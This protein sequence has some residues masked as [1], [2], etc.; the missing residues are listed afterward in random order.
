M[1]LNYNYSLKCAIVLYCV[2]TSA[3]AK[4]QIVPDTTLRVNSAI[5]KSGS[6]FVI[7]GGTQAGS[8]LFHSFGQF[9]VPKDTAALFNNASTIENI[10][11]RVT[12]GA[13]SNIDGVLRA[14]GTAN[15]FLIN[16]NGII[17]GPNASLNIGGSFIG[18][19]ASSINFADGTQFSVTSPQ[20][21][22]LLTVSIPVGLGFGSNPGAI[23][24]QGTGHSLM[25]KDPSF[26]PY[27]LSG[28][29]GLQV[30][31]SKTL[32]LV[33]GEIALS[34]GVLTA[35][36]GQVELGSVG[37]SDV[38][39]QVSIIPIA[40]G[41]TLDYAKVSSFGNIQ[42]GQQALVDVGGVSAG[43]IQAQGRQVSL[44]D[45]SVLW[46]QNRGL[47]P[48]GNISVNATESL[49][50]NGAAANPNIRSSLMT[51]ALKPGSSGNITVSTPRLIVQNGAAIASR[52]FGQ[53][54]GGNIQINAA[55]LIQASGYAANH[56]EAYSTIGSL[57]FSTGNAGNVAMSTR[58]VSILDGAVLA[59][60]T[61]GKG[62]S[63]NLT[64]NAETVEVN[65]VIPNSS[66]SAIATSSNGFGN[67][68][69][70]TLNT[71]TLTVKDG[72]GVSAASFGT[73]FSGSITV[74]AS[75]LVEMNGGKLELPLSTRITSSVLIQTSTFIRQLFGLPAIPNANAGSV[76][77]NT[78]VFRMTNGAVVSVKNEGSGN[79]GV[80]RINAGSLL[81][82]HQSSLGGTTKSGEGGN[83]FLQAND[84]QLRHNS[85]ITATAGGTGNGGN[86]TINSGAI[87]QLESSNITANAVKGRGGNIQIATSG[88]FPSAD[89]NI[90][91]SSQIGISGQVQIST[92]EINQ[93]NN[94][95]QQPSNFVST[96][97]VVATSC[98]AERNIAQ[99]RFVVTGNG[100]LPET[101]DADLELPYSVVQVRSSTAARNTQQSKTPAA[102][103]VPW[104]V[105]DQVLEATQLV[106]TADGR[107]LLLAN[108]T[109]A[110]ANS[111]ALTCS[112]N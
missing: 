83:I 36:G 32:A 64:I 35:P 2:L 23:A 10:F 56:P 103:S 69:N 107:L 108:P 102:S 11:A 99:G 38:P 25:A 20:T 47:Q 61:F 18:S 49:E 57:T 63:G 101:P 21:S 97:K 74:N 96:E 37:K 79:G 8:N 13:I 82:D 39:A 31:P 110:I 40:Q 48:A 12:G 54:T 78:D 90:T 41:F 16:P 104:K 9:N 86:I 112:S 43:A 71:Q 15:L 66:A 87:A 45:G 19:T 76:T 59:T 28:N 89:S 77:I 3:I 84:L 62:S 14:N 70:L 100:G 33:G 73:G 26:S 109:D 111:Q 53:G 94:L 65:G 92:P 17:F 106:A 98:L 22:P 88:L 27:Q 67:A 34:G 51:E 68:G 29:T 72:G 50:L 52:T 44:N 75:K 46:S 1:K 30:Q 93:Q 4:G 7:N 6:T 91:A 55:E 80:L 60:A 5:S 81:L 105:G 58:Q 42:L 85:A 24:V 95:V